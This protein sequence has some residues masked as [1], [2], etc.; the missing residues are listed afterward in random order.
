[1]SRKCREKFDAV[2]DFFGRVCCRRKSTPEPGRGH[3]NGAVPFPVAGGPALL[4]RNS[5]R[6]LVPG[7]QDIVRQ[8]R[9]N[10]NLAVDLRKGGL[11]ESERT[12]LPEP[13][14]N[15]RNVSRL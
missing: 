12:L 8:N 10:K 15:H 1:L 13:P 3:R 2:V 14:E 5:T 11:P 9:I 7:R 4:G 6:Q